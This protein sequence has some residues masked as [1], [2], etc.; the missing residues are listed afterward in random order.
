MLDGVNTITLIK[1]KH[2]YV[3]P[4]KVTCEGGTATV[5]KI[6]CC[7]AAENEP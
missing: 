2:S 1:Y 6:K 3:V 7:S 5:A 4:V